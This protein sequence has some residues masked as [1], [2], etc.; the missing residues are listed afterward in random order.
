MERILL[1]LLIVFCGCS[2]EIRTYSDSD[3]EYPVHH[4][5]TYT[6]AEQ[7][8]TEWQS[9]PLYY[10]ELTDKRIKLAVD[11]LLVSKGYVRFESGADLSLH[12]HIMVE[13]RSMLTTDPYGHFYGASWLES[14]KSIFQYR[15]GTLIV[16][17][18]HTKLNALVWRGWAVAALEV[19]L[20]DTKNRDTI[21]K[22]VI[23][24]IMQDFPQSDAG[25][26]DTLRAN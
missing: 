18:V 23:A 20:Y 11:D 12:Y 19:V 3:K 16:D 7:S 1:A 8:K 4:Y 5:K 2:P 13:D 6:W 14:G 17:V 10:N 24:K 15:E 26:Q 9:N 25:K 21:I 22:S